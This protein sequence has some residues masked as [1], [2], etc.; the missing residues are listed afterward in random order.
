MS[1]TRKSD[2][3]TG[4]LRPYAPPEIAWEEEYR[5]TAFG[6]SCAKMPGD[7]SCTPVHS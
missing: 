5:P 2:E 4:T 6:V 7:L 3:S 1:D